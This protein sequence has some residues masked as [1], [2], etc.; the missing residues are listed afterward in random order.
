MSPP[1]W[2]S[3]PM[4]PLSSLPVMQPRSKMLQLPAMSRSMSA[5]AQW[6][7][8]MPSPLRPSPPMWLE[9]NLWA[10][11]LSWSIMSLLPLK[12]PVARNTALLVL[13][14][15]WEPSSSWQITP[16]TG[17]PGPSGCTSSTAF[18]L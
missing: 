8:L 10:C 16:V 3:Q 17:V 9:Q 7:I 5:P 14:L 6:A 4:P 11:T 15:M 12:P 18:V 2:P 1:P 13:Y